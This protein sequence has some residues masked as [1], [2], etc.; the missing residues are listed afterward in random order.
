VIT[1]LCAV[2]PFRSAISRRTTEVAHHKILNGA[3][4]ADPPIEQPKEY[5]FVEVIQ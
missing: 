2:D 1:G 3:K 5:E 4:P